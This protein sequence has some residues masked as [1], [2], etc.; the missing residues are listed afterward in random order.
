MTKLKP[1][2][3]QLAILAKNNDWVGLITLLTLNAHLFPSNYIPPLH[4]KTKFP[5][6]TLTPQ[7]HLRVILAKRKLHWLSKLAL[8][9]Y[10]PEDNFTQSHVQELMASLHSLLLLELDYDPD[11]SNNDEYCETMY[12]PFDVFVEFQTKS[13]VYEDITRN[14]N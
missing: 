5:L 11:D 10:V 1:I 13:I 9:S 3:K 8:I 2:L 7:E 4:T 12:L 14:F 6:E